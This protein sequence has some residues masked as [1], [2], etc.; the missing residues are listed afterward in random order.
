MLL[1][2]VHA[3]Y[4]VNEL[5]SPHACEVGDNKVYAKREKRYKCIADNSKEIFQ[6]NK[7]TLKYFSCPVSI[8]FA[9]PMYIELHI[10]KKYSY[11]CPAL[12]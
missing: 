8:P 6:W 10:Q 9:A 3:L 12:L 2:S 4:V 7:T 5:S 11:F 1:T